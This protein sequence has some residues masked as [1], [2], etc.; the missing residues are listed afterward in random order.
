MKVRAIR[1]R[2]AS[3]QSGADRPAGDLPVAAG[4]HLDG[5]WKGRSKRALALAVAALALAGCG[6]SGDGGGGGSAA[7]TVTV[8]APLADLGGEIGILVQ[9]RYVDDDRDS[10]ATTDFFADGD[11]DLATTQ[12]QIRIA[13]GRPELDGATQSFSWNTAGRPAGTYFIVARVSDGTGTATDT[14]PGRVTLNPNAPPQVTVLFPPA[15]S[16]TDAAQ[17][18]ITGRAS[19]PQGVKAVRVNGVMAGSTDGFLTWRVVAPLTEDLINVIRVEAEDQTGNLDS[20]AAT[21]LVQESATA[22]FGSGPSTD[23]PSCGAL[24]PANGRILV[25]EETGQRL[26]AVDR[27]TGD[28]SVVSDATVGSGPALQG[29]LCVRADGTRA[30]VLDDGRRALFAIDLATG[31]R[32]ILSDDTTGGG[33]FF[34]MPHALAVDTAN[35]RVLVAD[36][37]LGLLCAVDLTSG[38]RSFVAGPFTSPVGVALDAVDNRAYVTDDADD[39]LFEVDLATGATTVI[40]ML[41]TGSGTPFLEPDGVAVDRVRNRALVADR[42]RDGLLAV[43]LASGDRIFLSGGGLGRGTAFADPGD[44]VLDPTTNSLVVADAGLDVV[45]GVE[46]LGGDRV[47]LSGG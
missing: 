14:A 10:F 26:L 19:D 8:I 22:A 13:T 12:D 4:R 2:S 11:G 45:F 47:V 6:S 32:T 43:D 7:P 39:A 17:V 27:A 35:N 20:A 44:V 25:V 33:T 37:G 46:L 42:G 40:S 21:I 23:R 31:D 1:F 29:R 9:I 34:I 15:A 38:N 36:T 28:R 30:L 3:A 24:D 18:T 5:T 16:L 41:G